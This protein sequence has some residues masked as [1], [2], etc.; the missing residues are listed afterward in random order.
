MDRSDLY[1]RMAARKS[2]P[3]DLEPYRGDNGRVNRCVA[4]FKQGKLQQGGVLLDVGGGIGDLAY[5]CKD[6]F[7][8]VIVVDI[9]EQ[10]RQA[11]LNKGA[12]FASCDV[13]RQ[14]LIGITD[15]RVDVVTALDFIEHI[16]DPESFANEC[17]RVLRPG[18]Q[19]FINTPNIRFWKHIHE[20]FAMG[21]FPHTSGDTEVFHGGHLAFYTYSDMRIVFGRAGFSSFE[22]F[23]DEECYDQPPPWFAQ[24]A[25]A[26]GL[27]IHGQKEYVDFCLEF[28]C[29]NLLMKAVKS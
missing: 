3:K 26:M 24:A 17:F 5:A 2:Q 11:V 21:T 15:E 14:G 1:E 6:M 22:R 10:N 19:V 25:S 28:G 20:L 7:N 8:D 12:L 16:I 23:K 13:D 4:L 27:S 9:C 29:P 18:G